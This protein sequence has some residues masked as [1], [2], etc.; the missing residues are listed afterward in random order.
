MLTGNPP[1]YA[2]DIQTMYKL[3]LNGKVYYPKSMSEDAKLLLE[4]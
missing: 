1:F 4:V 3:I 2:D